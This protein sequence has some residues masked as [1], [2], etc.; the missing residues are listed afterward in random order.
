MFHDPKFWLAIAF[1][2]FIALIIKFARATITK[3]LEGKSKLIAEEI[4]AA[5]ELKERAILLLAKAEK[6]EKDSAN[7]AAKLLQDAEAEAQKYA[8][9]AAQMVE[10]EIAKKTAASA[11]RIKMEEVIA[12]REIKNRIVNLAVANLSENIG[13][14]MSAADHEKVISKALGDFEKV[15]L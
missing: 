2:T 8:A 4:L 14:E 11:E 9:E 3:S 7:Y 15:A 12:V 13:K 5:K 1:I 6:Y 10:S